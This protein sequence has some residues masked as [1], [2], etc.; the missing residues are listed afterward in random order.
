MSR[1]A[2]PVINPELFGGVEPVAGGNTELLAV[3]VPGA[4]LEALETVAARAG[5]SLPNVVRELLWYHLVPT[6]FRQ[7]VARL[8][9]KDVSELSNIEAYEARLRVFRTL[10]ERVEVEALRMLEIR[11]DV[12]DTALEVEASATAWSSALKEL[13]EEIASAEERLEEPIFSS[14]REPETED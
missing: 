5:M 9:A 6:L 1:R 3:R 8:Q 13:L 4:L 7:S 10:S 14:E 12:R 11:D 2:E